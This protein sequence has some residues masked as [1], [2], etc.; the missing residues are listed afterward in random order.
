M[1]ER[2]QRNAYSGIKQ[3]LTLLSPHRFVY[4]PGMTHN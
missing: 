3:S 1:S 2:D 4:T